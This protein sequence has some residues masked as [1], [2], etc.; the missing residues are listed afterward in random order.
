MEVKCDT[1]EKDPGVDDDL[2]NIA[3]CHLSHDRKYVER[4][5]SKPYLETGTKFVVWKLNSICQSAIFYASE[6][7]PSRR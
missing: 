4:N 1:G 2:E 3:E 7:C 5:I 6:C